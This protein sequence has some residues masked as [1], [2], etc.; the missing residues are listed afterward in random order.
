MCRLG[1]QRGAIFRASTVA[2]AN[3]LSISQNQT[4]R[5]R[6]NLV[7]EAKTTVKVGVLLGMQCQG[8]EEKVV[9]KLV[10]NRRE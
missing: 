4:L 2:A 7:E 8:Q 6:S 3:S 10:E 5:R 9:S 1:F